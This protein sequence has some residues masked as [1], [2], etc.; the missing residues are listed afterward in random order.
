M[1][2]MT[3]KPTVAMQRERDAVLQQTTQ[4][5]Q[6]SALFEIVTCPSSAARRRRQDFF[7]DSIPNVSPFF[8]GCARVSK[9]LISTRS[10][11]PCASPS[12]AKDQDE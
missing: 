9:V 5:K 11:L 6:H 10:C 2:A 1:I 8:E 3:E 12:G 4:S 7:T